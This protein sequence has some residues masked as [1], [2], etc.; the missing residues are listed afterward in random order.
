MQILIEEVWGAAW[1][2]IKLPDD[3]QA[4]KPQTPV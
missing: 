4:A 1:D 2:S 3:A